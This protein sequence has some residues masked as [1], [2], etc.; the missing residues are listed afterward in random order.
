MKSLIPFLVLLGCQN[1]LPPA[2]G[3]VTDPPPAPTTTATVAPPAPP[4][5]TPALSDEDA[6]CA[7][8]E[9]LACVSRDG[10][11]LWE[12]TPGGIAC[13]DVF[14]NAT[15]NGVDLGARC[16]ADMTDCDQRSACSTKK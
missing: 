10:R 7:K 5:P 4:A 3:P 12:P 1:C 13:A 9:E 16:I 15:K 8:F 11:N 6:A 2:P 14:R